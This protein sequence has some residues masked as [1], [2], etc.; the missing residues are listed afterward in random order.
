MDS[1]LDL[2]N[3]LQYGIPSK[4]YD[5]VNFKYS[6]KNTSSIRPI[7]YYFKLLLQCCDIKANGVSS[8]LLL[9]S[10][11]FTLSP[12]SQAFIFL[13]W[14]DFRRSSVSVLPIIPG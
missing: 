5:I 4:L 7:F 14:Q 9:G 6:M 2:N 12:R 3:I 10:M 1:F 13:A 11:L 8:L